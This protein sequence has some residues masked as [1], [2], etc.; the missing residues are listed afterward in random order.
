MAEAVKNASGTA[1]PAGTAPVLRSVQGLP[2]F[3]RGDSLYVQ[4]Q[5]YNVRHQAGAPA[6]LL[7]QP[8][9]LRGGVVLA[10]AAPEPMDSGA[11]GPPV[12]VSRIALQSFEAGDYELRLTVTDRGAN[13]SVAREVP[14][15][16]E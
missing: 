11:S 13:A 8:A 15:T 2:R 3:G 5:A 16:V 7:V 14:F 12:H 10:T 6:E 4:V 1:A 9:V